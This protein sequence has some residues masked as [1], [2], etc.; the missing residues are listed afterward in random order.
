[1]AKRKPKH[2]RRVARRS[3]Q[4]SEQPTPCG[5]VS[6]RS[7]GTDS[8]R[9]TWSSEGEAGHHPPFPTQPQGTSSPATVRSRLEWIASQAQKY[10]HSKFTTLAHHLDVAMLE[11]A[12]WRLNPRS[13]PGIDRVTW[14]SYERDLER[15]LE[16]LHERLVR[17]TYRPQAVVRHWI[18]KGGGKYRPLGIPTVCA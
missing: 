6:P 7:Q 11:H 3:A 15:N 18:S 2:R 1:M 8:V 14:Q 10:P 12:F 4:P 9:G 16:N 5:S 17:G 13:S